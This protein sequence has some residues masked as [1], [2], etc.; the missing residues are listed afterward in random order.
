MVIFGVFN[1]FINFKKFL[2]HKC[3]TLMLIVALFACLGSTKP[4]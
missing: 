4:D 2:Q 1:V 3:N